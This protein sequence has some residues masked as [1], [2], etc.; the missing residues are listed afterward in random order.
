MAI[1]RRKE[2]L[3]ETWPKSERHDC[4][5]ARRRSLWGPDGAVGVT[6][7]TGIRDSASGWAEGDELVGA[8]RAQAATGMERCVRRARFGGSSGRAPVMDERTTRL[9]A[10]AGAQGLESLIDPLTRGGARSEERRLG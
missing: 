6:W 1:E 5:L 9:W 8:R 3:C 4:G 7:A 10:A 2:A